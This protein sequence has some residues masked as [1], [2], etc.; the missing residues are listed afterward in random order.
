MSRIYPFPALRPTADAAPRVAAVP[1]DV[2]NTEEAIALAAGNAD[3][4]LHVSRPEIDLPSGIDPHSDA[5]Y[6]QAARSFAALRAAAPL[7]VEDAP[8]YYVYRLTMGAH[9]QAGIAACFSIDEYD[10]DLIKKHEKTRPDK[11]DDRTRHMI[12]IRAQ[13]GPVFLTYR[14]S[15][16]VDALVAGVVTREP[17]FDFVA[18]DE[19]RHEIWRVPQSE[20]QR[21]ESAFG[22]M[23]NLYIADGHHRAASA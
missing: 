21:L 15:T 3:S 14:A 6:E 12:A 8:S 13:T 19:I 11:E 9:V 23:D 2:V 16:D 18:P 20:H 10:R 17:F 22:A 7:V 4:F 5:V 1:Y